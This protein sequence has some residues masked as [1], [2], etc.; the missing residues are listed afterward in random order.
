MKINFNSITVKTLLHISFFS[1]AFIFFV[2]FV[3]RNLFTDSYMEL[4]KDK[5]ALIS[6][7]IAGPI[8][9]NLSYDFNEAMSEIAT[10]ALLNENVL[11]L[12]I[13][14]NTSSK[15]HNYS[16]SPLTMQEHKNNNELINVQELID[17]ATNTKIGTLTIVYSNDSYE[18]YMSN[19]N[20][21]FFWGILGFAFSLFVLTFFLYR[22]LK[23]LSI[24]DES[25]KNF[26]PQ[27]PQKLNLTTSSRDEIFSISKSANTMIENIINFL[28]KTK[29]LNAE[30][31]LSQ[32]HLKDAQR[33]AKV[34]SLN[35]NVITEELVLS[36]E[37]YRILGV[38]LNTQFTWQDF[39][40][41]IAVEDQPRVRSIL[42]DAIIRGSKFS[43][44]YKLSLANSRVIY[45]QTKGK[46]R[47]KKDRD[48]KITAISMDITNDVKNKQIIEQLAYFDALTGLAN[49][50]LL[51]DRMLKSIQTARREEEKIGVIFLDLDHFKLINDTLGHSVG[52]EL[53]VYISTVLKSQIR[54]SDTLS[55]LGGDEFLI[56][57]PSVNNI[58]DVEKFAE[59]IQKV[60]EN[61]HDIGIHQ[62]YITSSIGVAVFPEHGANCDELIR[63]AD[64]AMY[65]AKNGGRNRYK[66][67]SQTMGNFVDKQLH[68]E[69]DLTEAVKTKDQIQVY[70]QVKI[71]T[72]TKNILGAEALVRWN[73][74]T[75]GLIFPDEFI[76][77]AE[78]TGLMIEL[79]N[80]ITDKSI[81]TIKE[82]NDIGVIAVKMA[83][84]L[85]ARQF[86]DANLVPFISQTLKK[87][88]IDP[89]Q[90]EFEIT[91][92]I[93][94]SNMTNTLRILKE[95]R[96]LGVSIAIDD[97]GTGHSS[98]AYLKKF[99]INTL[100]IDKSFV[101]GIVDDEEDRVI[102][103]TIISMAHSLGLKTVAE[104]V[105][106]Q[107][108]V[109]MLQN[110][111]CDILQG[112]F[113]SKPITKDAFFEFVKGYE[114]NN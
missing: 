96:E 88:N 45:I 38:K 50:T 83:I 7:Q 98:L 73:H 77:M 105:E 85:S 58:E 90:V 15:G 89:S 93:S 17:P 101:D 14:N 30:L 66:I 110:M 24:L 35:Y 54:D 92:S 97:F 4:E 55:R 67:Y 78:S 13:N 48:T 62:L 26:D 43:I 5:V 1:L 25:L 6:G 100:K 60:L 9:L 99:P 94:M 104:G 57:L 74:P 42:D 28:D 32:V 37:Y 11:Q 34:G 19:F 109:D 80:I 75:S 27:K 12:N 102:A 82:L 16:N 63:N 91:E 87:Y 33:M 36:D 71:D 49:R 39:L 18:E 70:Y 52:D 20:K 72:V 51:K 112:Y 59:K 10:K 56:L 41:L 64:T 22:S 106:T 95:L 114:T 68:L 53:L 79:G 31:L 23:N 3:V 69:Q 65:E 107:E 8:A 44:K 61:K 40:S 46:V 108:H 103:Q 84:N 47:K 76:Y 113:Y 86:Q 2:T 81:A 21:W 29:Q 111:E